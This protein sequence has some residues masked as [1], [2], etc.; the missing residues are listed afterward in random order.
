MSGQFQGQV[1]II[2][3]AAS[4]LGLAIVHRIIDAHGGRIVVRNKA[5]RAARGTTVQLLLPG[6]PASEAQ[7]HRNKPGGAAEAA[8]ALVQEDAG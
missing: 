8:L 2:T 1:A 5:A 4:G 3:G 7:N 6:S